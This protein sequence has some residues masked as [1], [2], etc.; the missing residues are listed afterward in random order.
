MTISMQP[1]DELAQYYDLLYSFKNY[2][3]EANLIIKL[4][5]QYKTTN[6]NT[7]LD[8]ACGTGKHLNTLK[9]HFKCIGTDLNE[10]MLDI[11][12]INVP[13]VEFRQA[14]M[15]SFSLNQTFDVITCLFS[16]IGY[17]KTYDKLT[18]TWENISKHLTIGGVAIVEPWFMKE[19]YKVGYPHM[20]IY[21]GDEVKISRMNVSM[22]IGMLSILD[23]HYL[24]AV[25]DQEVKYF[26]EHHEL[27][28]FEKEKI[29]EIM[30]EVGL[31]AY[32]LTTPP[33]GGRGMY[34]GIK[35]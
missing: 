23:F 10:K 4:I 8:I 27:A 2:E 15:V 28:M 26:Q 9:R 34:I 7:L 1:F 20:T 30:N 16:S 11:A 24:V 31:E 5:N 14:D 35:K 6:G 29:L 33:I 19:Q 21:D 25:R 3:A 13:E 22:V 12:R 18:S 32:F 17:V